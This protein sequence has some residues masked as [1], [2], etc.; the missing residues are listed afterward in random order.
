MSLIN[1]VFERPSHERDIPFN[2]M[3]ERTRLPLEQVRLL[4]QYVCTYKHFSSMM[5]S[6]MLEH[7]DA[8]TE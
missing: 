3:A 6:L 5:H 1:M 4:P 2:E 7:H 8:Y